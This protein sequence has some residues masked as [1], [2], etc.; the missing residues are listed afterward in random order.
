MP[1]LCFTAQ[2]EEQSAMRDLFIGSIRSVI[3][4]LVLGLGLKCLISKAFCVGNA[5]AALMRT[6]GPAAL[7][8][9]ARE[10]RARETYIKI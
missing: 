7:T 3:G 2:Q 4:A 8:P 5:T 10:L 6:L 9:K 1:S